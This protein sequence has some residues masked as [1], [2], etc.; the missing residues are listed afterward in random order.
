M[1]KDTL[2]LVWTDSEDNKY[3][4]GTLYK[5]DN[6]Y[7]F[8][9]NLEEV[10]KAMEK[11][12]TLLIPFPNINATYD[13]PELFAIFGARVPDKKRPEI[14]KILE[15]YDLTEYDEF[16]LLKKTKGKV[17]TDDYE[18]VQCSLQS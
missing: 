7:H 1:E 2:Y 11:G 3:K 18:F 6:G 12:F 8:K 4:V 5:E 14:K 9:Y 17:Q 15:T 13:N 16:E 10:K